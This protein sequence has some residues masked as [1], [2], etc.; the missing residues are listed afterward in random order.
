[1]GRTELDLF[2]PG[3]SFFSHQQYLLSD[4]FLVGISYKKAL[5]CFSWVWFHLIYR[6]SAMVSI[7]ITA[8]TC[9]FFFLSYLIDNFQDQMKRELAYREEM[10]QQLQIVSLCL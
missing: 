3:K 4:K 6:N 2:F 7:L 1:M 10:V 9:L 5:G 8:F